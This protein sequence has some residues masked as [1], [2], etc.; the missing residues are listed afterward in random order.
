M[1]LACLI[2]PCQKWTYLAGCPR[3]THQED[4]VWCGEIA[5]RR[6]WRQL[7]CKKQNST[8]RQQPQGVLAVGEGLQTGSE[9]QRSSK[10]KKPQGVL[11]VGEGLQTGSEQ[12]CSSRRKKPQGVLAVGEGLQTGSEQQRSSRRKSYPN[13]QIVP[14]AR[15]VVEHFRR[16]SNKKQHECVEK[17]SKPV[18]MRTTWSSTVCR[19]SKIVQK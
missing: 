12:Q 17:R 3:P 6:T 11:A 19:L 15:C 13:H 2:I 9:Q 16:M 10:R 18:C 14:A 7:V 5:S 4:P 8:T 1:L